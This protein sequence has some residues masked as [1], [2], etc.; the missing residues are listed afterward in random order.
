MKQFTSRS[1]KL[2]E[3]GENMAEMFLVKHGYIIIERNYTKKWGEIDIVAWDSE[4]ALCFI[5]VKSIRDLSFSTQS[6]NPFENIT[7]RK[8]RR[9]HRT[10]ETY[11]IERRVSHETKIR[12]LG[13]AVKIDKDNALQEVEILDLV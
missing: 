13:V 11:I 2:G 8:L 6:Y 12:V 5:E 10:I 4:K 7:A 3:L 9:L 1:Q